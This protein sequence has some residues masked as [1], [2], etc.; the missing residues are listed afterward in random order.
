[1][2]PLGI[3]YDGAEQVTL[4]P[5]ASMP[6]G[7]YRLTVRGSAG[8]AIHDLSGNSLD[9]D[10]N[11]LPGGD[12]VRTF[13]V[14]LPNT[15][16]VLAQL[17]DGSATVG[18]AFAAGG[19]FIDPDDF[20]AWTA[21]VDYGDGAGP[22]PLSLNAD[23]TFNLSHVYVDPGN[24]TIALTVTD[25]AGAV[26]A[27]SFHVQVSD[28]AP[29]IT[30]GNAP[31]SGPEGSPVS[32]SASASS[33]AAHAVLTYRWSVTDNG[34]AFALP[35]NVD[36]SSPTLT[37]TPPDNGAYV[38]SLM[39][40]DQYGMS[41]NVTSDLTVTNVTPTVTLS[42]TG[43]LAVANSVVT[44]TGLA[45]DPGANDALTATI[46]YGDGSGVVPLALNPADHSFIFSHAYKTAGSYNVKVMVTDKDGASATATYHVDV[47]GFQVNDGSA[48][49]S[50]V[51]S[52]TVTFDQRY[53]PAPGAFTLRRHS[54]GAMVALTAT[55][56][57]GDGK[58]WV[59]TFS[60]SNVIGGSVAD[61]TWNL[62]IDSSLLMGSDNQPAGGGDL[63]Y[64]F[65][66]LFGDVDG[67]G[68]V[69][70]LDYARMRQ[71]LNSSR[72]SANYLWYLDYD[73]SGT[74]DNN[75]ANQFK[76]RLGTYVSR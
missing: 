35:G 39:V 64:T 24:Y 52:L 19:S 25:A 38:V 44:A 40:S 60:G 31:A 15:A 4:T 49:R 37:F 74:I 75:D 55:N 57:S 50:M 51:D 66:R 53:T 54:D 23:H 10:D 56:P 29:T 42:S 26:A 17:A 76:L 14:R 63:T 32:F 12:Y 48:Q 71:V 34:T 30:L 11:G 22:Q 18:S 59:L 69:D 47:V 61:G 3:S 5:L 1:V 72:G 67:D 62:T 45:S 43:T 7:P 21:T 58:T 68:D 65:T 70:T 36:V 33:P 13:L 41:E 27:G 46:D 20:D 28:V 73:N 8:A 2:I 6:A 9:G 16:P